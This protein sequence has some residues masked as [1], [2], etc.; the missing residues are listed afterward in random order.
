MIYFIPHYQQKSIPYVAD[1]IINDLT[2]QYLLYNINHK[3]RGVQSAITKIL[4]STI[5]CFKIKIYKK[6]Q[7]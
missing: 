6:N 1:E 5:K 4:K 2:R 3:S 7:N